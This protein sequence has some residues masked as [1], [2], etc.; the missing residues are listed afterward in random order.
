MVDIE[1]TAVFFEICG[2]CKYFRKFIVWESMMS[3]KKKRKATNLST[4][5]Y[6]RRMSCQGN[7][8]GSAIQQKAKKLAPFGIQ[9]VAF[10]ELRGLGFY[11][12]VTFPV[13]FWSD[14]ARLSHLK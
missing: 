12:F 7:F 13:L 6:L 5:T 8:T 9:L 1:P 4:V 10:E 2:I 11:D 3:K 14:L